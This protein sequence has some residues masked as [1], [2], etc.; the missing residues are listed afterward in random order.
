MKVLET[1]LRPGDVVRKPPGGP[2]MIVE[3]VLGQ[4]VCCY[5]KTNGRID[6]GCFHPATIEL[7]LTADSEK[8]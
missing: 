8:S 2:L 3:S 1:Y 6:R 7:L 4:R 5:W